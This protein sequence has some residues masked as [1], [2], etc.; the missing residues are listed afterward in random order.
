M[1][2]ELD[3]KVMIHLQKWQSPIFAER[4]ALV[5]TPSRILYYKAIYRLDRVLY[6]LNKTEII[7]ANVWSRWIALSEIM[8]TT[9]KFKMTRNKTKDIHTP[10]FRDFIDSL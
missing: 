8:M 9:P 7:N 2:P 3:S 5:D 1:M 4:F 10:E 6:R